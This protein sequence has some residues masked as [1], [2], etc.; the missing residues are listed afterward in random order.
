MEENKKKAMKEKDPAIKQKLIA[1]IEKDEELLKAKYQE[2][3]NYTSK[4]K[5]ID[6]S[7]HVSDL[8]ER[9]KRAVE[10]KSDKP[11]GGSGGGGSSGGNRGSGSSSDP[12]GSNGRGNGN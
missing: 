4:F 10:G 12:F 11:R 1:E 7:K 2:R 5:Y 9:L 6:I 3:N 8:V